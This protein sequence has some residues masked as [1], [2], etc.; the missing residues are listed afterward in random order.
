[1][2]I[3]EELEKLQKLHESGFLTDNEL[4]RAKARVLGEE[5]NGAVEPVP[6]KAGED[7][8]VADHLEQIRWQNELEQLDREWEM[9]RRNYLVSDKYGRT[10]IPTEGGSL[11]GALVIGGF[12]LAW[13]I[14]AASIGAPGIFP[15][16]G[17]LFIV[18]GVWSCIVSFGKAG[19]HQEALARYQKRRAELLARRRR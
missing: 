5:V 7:S 8:L 15:L 9:E 14:G 1:M 17:I 3:S 10:S 11:A 12:G 6:L 4:A 19:D 16:F 18:F 2:N 13:S